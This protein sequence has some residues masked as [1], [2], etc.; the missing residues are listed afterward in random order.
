MATLTQ[1]CLTRNEWICGRYFETRGDMVLEALQEHVLLTVI[2][3]LAGFALA[4]PLAV[5]I[6]RYIRLQTPLMGL[7]TL[8]YTVP[9]LAMFSLLLPFTGLS[10]TTVIVGLALYSLTILVRGIHAGLQAV[11]PEARDAAIG[12]GYGPMRLLWKVELPLALP[13]LF[14]G[15]RVAAVSTVALAT[16]GTIVG[17]GGLG[18]LLSSGLTSLFKAQ[19]LV[20]AVLCVLLAFLADAV[21]IGLQ[22]VMTPWA[23]GRAA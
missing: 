7:A 8:I 18:D 20:A 13:A 10:A 1:D 14:A 21:L 3:L 15:L 16:I 19:V 22:K 2:S 5:V 23:R 12:L 4:L 11:P 17:F 6:H 9:S